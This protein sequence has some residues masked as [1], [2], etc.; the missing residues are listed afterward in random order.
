MY[1]LATIID[2]NEEATRKA[3]HSGK[4][5]LEFTGDLDNLSIPN[6]GN[7]VP[8]GW[9]LVKTYF[10]DSSGFGSEDEPAMTIEMFKR[11]LKVGYG[12][13][14]IEEGQFQVY[15]GEFERTKKEVR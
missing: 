10:V 4:R 8:R 12:Y 7:Y 6:L 9:K 1:S 13:A 5:P 15:V 14:V 3:K 11:Q 2:M